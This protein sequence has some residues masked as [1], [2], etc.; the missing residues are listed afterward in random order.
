MAP[1]QKLVARRSLHKES[2]MM[3][4][5]KYPGPATQQ[6][7]KKAR[8]QRATTNREM[9]E[10]VQEA[11][12]GN[13]LVIEFSNEERDDLNDRIKSIL[14]MTMCRRVHPVKGGVLS[15]VSLKID[16]L[17]ILILS[18]VAETGSWDRNARTHTVIVGD[19]FDPLEFTTETIDR[20][21]VKSLTLVCEE[22]NSERRRK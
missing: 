18:S 10:L 7:Q 13:R 17:S 16:E 1:R 9:I 21:M 2:K 5:K 6:P 20:D 11:R 15:H 19:H 8:G 12:T 3:R 14:S 22:A 4:R